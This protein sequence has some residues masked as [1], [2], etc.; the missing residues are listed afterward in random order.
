SP[1][2]SRSCRPRVWVPSRLRRLPRLPAAL[3]ADRPP[4]MND[5]S[6]DNLLR[7]GSIARPAASHRSLTSGER[8]EGY[9]HIKSLIL[10]GCNLLA[11]LFQFHLPLRQELQLLPH[12]RVVGLLALVRRRVVDRPL[13]E[14][15][16]LRADE[17]QLG[18]QV[19]QP[20]RR[21]LTRRLGLVLVLLHLLLLLLQGLDHLLQGVDDVL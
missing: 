19:E 6:R 4:R 3:T 15:H 16:L 8:G 5:E 10:P 1:E 12:Q 21:R 2:A 7:D 11:L 13:V 18:E 9:C 20:L 17:L 14:L